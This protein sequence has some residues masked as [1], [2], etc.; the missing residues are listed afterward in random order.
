MKEK[1]EKFIEYFATIPKEELEY[2]ETILK[3]D[4]ETKGAFIFAKKI[5]EDEDEDEQ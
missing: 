5:F 4:S 2:V 1:I 3:W